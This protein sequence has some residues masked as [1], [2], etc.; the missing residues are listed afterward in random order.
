MKNIILLILFATSIHAQTIEFSGGFSRSF[1]DFRVIETRHKNSQA[2]YD[3]THYILPEPYNSYNINLGIE[4]FDKKYFSLVSNVGFIKRGGVN[5]NNE[6]N[7][8]PRTSKNNELILKSFTFNTLI[9]VKASNKYF[10]LFFGTGPRIDYMYNISGNAQENKP[11]KE[12]INI[13]NYGIDFE[14]GINYDFLDFIVG[15]KIVHN[16]I[17]KDIFKSL[18]DYQNQKLYTNSINLT[19][20]YKL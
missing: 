9:R 18:A 5:P 4:Y 16:L 1:L 13:V 15:V 17:V 12:T 10:T 3:Y 19:L 11:V 14:S 2:F 8:F 20:G 7:E 6:F